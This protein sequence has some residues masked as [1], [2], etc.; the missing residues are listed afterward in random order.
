MKQETSMLT[1]LLLAVLGTTFAVPARAVPDDIQLPVETVSLRK[2]T[3]P[4]FTIAMQKCAICHSADYVAY[5]PP[6]MSQVQWTGELTKMKNTYG[7]PI[8]ANDI[9]LIGVYLTATYGDAKSLSAA[10]ATRDP[11]MHVAVGS[12]ASTDVQ[13]LLDKNACLGCHALQ[14]KIVGPAY[15]EVAAKYRADPQA[16]SKV[17]ASIREGGVGRWGTVPMP[18][19]PGLSEPQLKAL[20][21]FVLGQ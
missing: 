8:D 12:T 17:A 19:F 1:G 16:L 14:T 18:P 13:A 15:Q 11:G 3:L 4:G 2:S 21:G 5:Q 7:A 9:R 20:A 6:A 10:D